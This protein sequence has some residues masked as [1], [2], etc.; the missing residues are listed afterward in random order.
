MQYTTGDILKFTGFS[1]GI[2]RTIFMLIPTQNQTVTFNFV[3]CSDS[4]NNHY[5]V[6]QIGTQIW[7]AE[8]LKVTHFNN[9][10][11]IPNVTDNMQWNN[12]T[13]GAYCNYSNTSSNSNIYGRLYNWYAI[14]D[15]LNICPTGWHIPTNAEWTILTTYLGG[16]SV[17]GGKLKENCITYWNVPNIGATNESGFTAL[18]GGYRGINGIFIDVGGSGNWW[19]FTEITTY[20]AWA[21]YIYYTNSN[22]DNYPNS[23]AAGFSV[24]CVKD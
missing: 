16:V 13:T 22:V 9:S 2:Y 4:D 10:N 20:D 1:G 14:T 3:A 15:A 18:P 24:R 19:S 21:S 11:P 12:L 17:A 5:A 6:V 23:K 8:N 7:M